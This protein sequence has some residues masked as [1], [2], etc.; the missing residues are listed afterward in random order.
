MTRSIIILLWLFTV[1]IAPG[2]GAQSHD[3]AA[4]EGL[5]LVVQDDQGQ[6]TLIEFS[7]SW[8]VEKLK[9]EIASKL[10]LPDIDFKIKHKKALLTDPSSL[11]DYSIIKIT[12]K[13]AEPALIEV[14]VITLLNRTLTLKINPKS[15]VAQLKLMIE[16]E[17]GFPVDKMRLIYAGR[18]LEDSKT[19]NY[20]GIKEGST[21]HFVLRM[22]GD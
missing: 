7:K 1:S 15:T 21:I 6:R 10:N 11:R 22:A 5:P 3:I 19:L 12:R 13:P 20:Y 4:G 9:T 18:Q 17:E 14:F 2:Y 16:K 8:S